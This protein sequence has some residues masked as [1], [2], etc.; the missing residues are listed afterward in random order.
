[1]TK[2][3][4]IEVLD[5]IE[6]VH[7]VL[8]EDGNEVE[9]ALNMAIKALQAQNCDQCEVG[10]PCLYCEHEFKAQADRNEF[11]NW[12]APIRHKADG[13][14]IL[15]S[16]AI[17]VAS[18]YCHPSNI[19]KELE[20]LSSV[21][22]PT[23][24]YPQVDGITP[25]VM[26]QAELQAH[27]IQSALDNGT[28]TVIATGGTQ[29]DGEYISRTELLKAIDTWDRFGVDDTNSLFRL[30]NLSLPHY[31]A[32]IHYDDVVKCIK[33]LPSVAIPSAE[34]KTGHWISMWTEKQIHTK[35]G[36]V[37]ESV[38]CSECDEWLTA[39]DEYDCYGRYCPNCGARMD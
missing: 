23:M 28:N 20:K 3:R 39:S 6:E 4:A 15:K 25:T 8:P 14:Y 17:R 30:D 18:G 33:G 34:P 27:V 22:I 5:G 2:E 7:G 29:T 19:A 32:Y 16:E 13:E 38:K 36:I 26:A 37:S 24:V 11:Y 12:D 31:V 9:E 10:N 21:A 35:D 1:M